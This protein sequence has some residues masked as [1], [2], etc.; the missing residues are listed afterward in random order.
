[1]KFNNRKAAQVAAFF[2]KEEGGSTEVL[3]L[4]KLMYLAERESIKTYGELITGDSFCAMEYGPVLSRTYDLTKRGPQ[5][6]KKG[7]SDWISER[8]GNY[9]KLTREEPL[10]L[11]SRADFAVL[12]KVWD[13]FGHLTPFELA[14]E[15]H[16]LCAEWQDPGKSSR[17][18]SYEN[19]AIA[20]GHN[21]IAAEEIS[22]RIS[23]QRELDTYLE[24]VGA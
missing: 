13:D 19:T 6:A 5:S 2:L 21:Q 17:P 22:Q 8:D 20:V 12:R 23:K 18:I 16:R 1:M 24:N 9:L 11:L 14:E 3:K 15:T 7:W 10:D 4:M